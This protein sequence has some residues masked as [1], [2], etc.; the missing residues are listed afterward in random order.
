MLLSLDDLKKKKKFISFVYG[1][2]N[3][4]AFVHKR[5]KITVIFI[6]WRYTL[7]SNLKVEW[8]ICF[9]KV[10]TLS[11]FRPHEDCRSLGDKGT[12]NVILKNIL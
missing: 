6:K 7:H 5:C 2:N 12:E 9:A 1:K 11:P 8:D 4:F 3:H 10:H